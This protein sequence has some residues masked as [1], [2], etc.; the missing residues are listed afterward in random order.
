VGVSL[1]GGFVTALAER[2][3]RR[4]GA[5]QALSGAGRAARPE[6]FSALVV[7]ALPN[8]RESLVRRLRAL[9]AREVAEAGTVTE[10][11]LLAHDAGPRTLAVVELALPDGSGLALLDELR[12]AGWAHGVVVTGTDDHAA[13]RAS[14]ASGARGLLVSRPAPVAAATPGPAIGMRTRP[15][16]GVGGLSGREIEVLQL[17][18]DGRSNRD[19]GSS[20]GLSAL[21][22]KSHLARIA[23][24]LGT[25]DRAEMVALALRGGLIH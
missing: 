20:L 13:V 22:V 25:G 23:R 18:A 8:A 24:K 15:A 2:S 19:V 14:L 6:R 3:G 16:A 12:S 21:T 1:A 5:A 17:V 9:G 4:T 11:R 7:V 10:A